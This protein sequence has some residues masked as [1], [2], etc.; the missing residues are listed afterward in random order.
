MKAM[1]R[2]IRESDVAITPD[3][4]K[5]PKYVVQEGAV[6]LARMSGVPVVPVT[7]ASSK[8]KIFGSWDDFN[9]PFPFSRGLF[10]WGEPFYVAR[11]ADIEESRLKLEKKM[12]ELTEFADSQVLKEN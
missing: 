7:F 2:S 10:V 5:G 6:A 1:I 3:G 11:D 9:L 12:R 8:K 4:P